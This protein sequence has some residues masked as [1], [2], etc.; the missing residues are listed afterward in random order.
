M[1]KIFTVTAFALFGMLAAS[2]LSAYSYDEWKF[3]PTV[4]PLIGIKNAD[5][6]FGLNLKL[7]K[8]WLG[9]QLGFAFG[10]TPSVIIKPGI[11][12]DLPFYLTFSK[13]NDFT[14]GPTFDAGPAFAF[15][16]GTA[17]DFFDIGLGFRT[18]Y[19]F[20]D[21]FGVVA[22]LVH[23]T[24]GF[25]RWISGVGFDSTFCMTYDIKLGIFW[26]I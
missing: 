3:E 23:F 22:E 21:S 11:V 16:G 20:S 17:I 8:E 19:R 26:M 14:F 7:G 4:A 10:G 24:M 18:A 9:G 25:A 2:N 13:A 12:V 1:K 5:T 6:R 15:S